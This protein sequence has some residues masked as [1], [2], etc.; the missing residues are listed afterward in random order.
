M[1]LLILNVKN[2]V[3]LGLKVDGTAAEAMQSLEDNHNKVT[4]MGLVNALRNL[5]T[6]YLIPGTPLSEHVSRLRTL[7]QVANDMD[8]KIDDT[9]FRTIFISLLGEE[10]DN[11][12]PALHTF[13]TSSEVI[14]F[15]S[16]HAERLNRVPSTSTS[17]LTTALAANTYDNRDARRAARKNLVCS[18]PQCGAPGRKGH[19]IADCFWPGGGKEGQWPSWWKGKRPTAVANNVE[20]FAFTA[21]TMPEA[22][23]NVY[24]GTGVQAINFRGEEVIASPETLMS[25]NEAVDTTIS[26]DIPDKNETASNAYLGPSSNSFEFLDMSIFSSEFDFLDDSAMPPLQRVEDDSDDEEGHPAVI[27]PYPEARTAPQIAAE[28]FLQHGQ[29]YPGDDHIQDERFL[30]YQTSEMEHIVMDS[31]IDEDV[32]IPTAFICD[33]KFDII[34]W[35]AAHRRRVLGLPFKDDD[36]SDNP[37]VGSNDSDSDSDGPDGPCGSVSAFVVEAQLGRKY[38]VVLGSEATEHCFWSRDD[39]TE[40]NPVQ[41][42]EGN[43]AEGS[44][45]CILGTGVVCKVITYQGRKKE[46]SLDAIHS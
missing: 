24:D 34:A 8:A 31:M 25:W 5:H 9:T 14:S 39:F 1:A 19:T 37:S 35:Y 15:V 22:I 17:T 16:M 28:A 43:A 44:K 13:K 10:W 23:V 30:V 29:P 32:P 21:W 11:V 7:S 4:E 45:F 46:I 41:S 36:P 3:G 6:A 42:R 40:C 18:N 27:G 26:V 12:V 20:T 38:V 2:P 33:D